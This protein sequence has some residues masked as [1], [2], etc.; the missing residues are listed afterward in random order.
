MTHRGLQWMATRG[1]TSRWI[2]SRSCVAAVHTRLHQWGWAVFLSGLLWSAGGVSPPLAH[3]SS[4]VVSDNKALLAVT[5]VKTTGQVPSAVL[6]RLRQALS[7]RTKL[8]AAKLKVVEAI[9]K[10]WPD[11]CLGLAKTDEI[12]TEALVVGWRVVMSDGKQRWIYRSDQQ[13]HAYRLE[14]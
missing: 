3:G 12:C 4:S 5:P 9:A 7:Q 13:A 6:T 14:P 8:P 1:M 2:V 11:G 10:T